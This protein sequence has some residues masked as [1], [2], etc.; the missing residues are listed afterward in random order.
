MLTDHRQAGFTIIELLVALAVLG[1]AMAT[2]MSAMLANT[3]LNN[4]VEKQ[5]NAMRVA[6]QV[7]ESY[8][9]RSDY[10]TLRA[11]LSQNVTMN[12][13]TYTAMTTFCPTDLPS[14]TLSSMPCNNT[15][16]YIRVEVRDGITAL[17]KVESY[18]TQF[19]S[20]S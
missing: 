18:F 16:V 19:G 12:G 17:Q 20:G 6:E 13:R 11:P 8:R 14:A 15:S 2:I 4:K 10:G 5:A 9:Q 7:M 1:I 3:N